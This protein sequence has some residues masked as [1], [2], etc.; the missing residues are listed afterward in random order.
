MVCSSFINFQTCSKYILQCIIG[1]WVPNTLLLST[2]KL[3]RYTMVSF[4]EHATVIV[5]I[6]QRW[7]CARVSLGVLSRR[8]FLTCVPRC[9]SALFEIFLGVKVSLK[10]QCNFS[11]GYLRHHTCIGP[12]S[13]MVTNITVSIQ[14]WGQH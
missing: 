13:F 3:P 2:C 5:T 4:L 10:T 6:Q 9:G 7:G 12:P 1:K 8:V 14:L 11:K